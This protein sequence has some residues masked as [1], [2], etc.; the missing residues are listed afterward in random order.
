MTASSKG[1][2]SGDDKAT[3][4]HAEAG[5]KATTG[6]SHVNTGGSMGAVHEPDHEKARK[7]GGK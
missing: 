1:A 6:T 7:A 2:R 3:A 4:L 5:A